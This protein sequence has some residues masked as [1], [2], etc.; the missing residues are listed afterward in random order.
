METPKPK[1]SRLP[2][3][4]GIVV[5]LIIICCF[6]VYLVSKIPST[7]SIEPPA[8]ARQTSA[9]IAQLGSDSSMI[10]DTPT[11]SMPSMTPTLTPSPINTPTPTMTQTPTETLLPKTATAAVR[12]TAEAATATAQSAN[13]TATAAFLASAKA[14]TATAQSVNKTATAASL[15]TANAIR[16]GHMTETSVAIE[17]THTA[18]AAAITATREAFIATA[19]EVASYKELYW[20]ELVTYPDKHIGEK[21]IVRGVIFHVISDSEFQMY[22]SGTYNAVWVTMMDSYTGIYEDT[23]VVVYGVVFGTQCGTNAFGA[24]I[25]QPAIIGTFFGK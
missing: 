13:K 12:A 20:K 8:A 25:C 17:A 11:P 3:I 9:S 18:R 2:L 5:L 15:A 23:S 6:G 7:G 24:E 16:Q 10:T 14:G 1:K 22:V 21:V 19:T 4:L